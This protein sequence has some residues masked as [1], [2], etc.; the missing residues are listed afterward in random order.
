[1]DK[2]GTYDPVSM[3]RE[4]SVDHSVNEPSYTATSSWPRK[5]SPSTPCGG[6]LLK[7]TIHDGR[8][9]EPERAQ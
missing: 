7:A 8:V 6:P 1:M 2:H 3:G 5:R 9:I 4:W